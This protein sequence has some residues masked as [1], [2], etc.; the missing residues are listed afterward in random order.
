[1]VRKGMI[2]YGK[3]HQKSLRQALMHC[4]P[5]L[6]TELSTRSAISVQIY[7]TLKLVCCSGTGDVENHRKE[8]ALALTRRS[9]R[10]ETVGVGVKARDV[11]GYLRTVPK[12]YWH[13]VIHSLR[14]RE[15]F[16]QPLVMG[17]V[18]SEVQ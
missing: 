4:L 13:M 16:G 3:L 8:R 12:V 7:Q 9:G 1:M 11:G 18:G 15:A 17:V 2:R 5:F 14:Y 6:D 10:S